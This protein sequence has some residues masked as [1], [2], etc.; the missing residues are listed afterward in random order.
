MPIRDGF[1]PHRQPH[2]SAQFN[3]RYTRTTSHIIDITIDGKNQFFKFGLR[4]SGTDK[5]RR[6]L[7]GSPITYNSLPRPLSG[8]LNTV[9]MGISSSSSDFSPL[10]IFTQRV[11]NFQCDTRVL[12]LAKHTSSLSSDLSKQRDVVRVGFCVATNE[13]GRGSFIQCKNIPTTTETLHT[14]S[15]AKIE[16]CILME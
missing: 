6:I 11:S 4:Q 13:E 16:S 12:G 8:I 7:M 5:Y 3:M 10:I 9:W 2:F 14:Q 1:T 15:I